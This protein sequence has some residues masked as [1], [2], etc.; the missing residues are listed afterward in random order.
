VWNLLYVGQLVPLKNVDILLRAISSLGPDTPV[1]LRL[2]YHNGEMEFELRKLVE[3]LGIQNQVE[4]VGRVAHEK[5]AEFHR[6][7]HALVLPSSSEALPSSVTEAMFSGVPIIASAVGGIPE[8]LNGFGTLVEPN[9]FAL[10]A[11]AIRWVTSN[12]GAALRNAESASESSRARY[13]VDAMIDGH[14]ALYRA[15]LSRPRRPTFRDRK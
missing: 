14:L 2:V 8:Q 4:F 5:L 11:E 1:Q 10:L 3:D 6:W 13:S 7:A 12:Y 15:L 9:N